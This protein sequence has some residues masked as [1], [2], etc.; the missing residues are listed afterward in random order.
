MMIELGKTELFEFC[1]AWQREGFKQA[2]IECFE[3]A[4]QHEIPFD[5]VQNE[6]G[7]FMVQ[8][9]LRDSK[10]VYFAEPVGIRARM[11]VKQVMSSAIAKA[12]AKRIKKTAGREVAARVA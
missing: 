2:A 3:W 5:I 6:V 12:R 11:N 7:S 8:L 4:V 10:G 1:D 9:T